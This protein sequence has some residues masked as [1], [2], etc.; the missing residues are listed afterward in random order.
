MLAVSPTPSPPPPLAEYKF[1]EEFEGSGGL[2][3]TWAGR[4]NELGSGSENINQGRKMTTI[5][6]FQTGKMVVVSGEIQ[7]AD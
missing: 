5:A 4:N 7:E 3:P 1:F 6:G 2:E